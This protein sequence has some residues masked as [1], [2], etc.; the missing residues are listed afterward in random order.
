MIARGRFASNSSAECHRVKENS[1]EVLGL[2]LTEHISRTSALIAK[3]QE[4]KQWA[5]RE[6][7]VPQPSRPSY[8]KSSVLGQHQP[9]GMCG[10]MKRCTFLAPTCLNL[11]H[12]PVGKEFTGLLL[13]RMS[14]LITSS[15]PQNELARP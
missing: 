1:L 8:V 9:H 15:D 11:I 3:T 5:R 10:K 12:P 6:P 14:H 2:L 4:D 7:T 13:L